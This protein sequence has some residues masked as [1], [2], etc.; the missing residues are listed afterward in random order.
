M[1]SYNAGL[2]IK[3]T[4]KPGRFMKF[5]SDESTLSNTLV[6]GEGHGIKVSID[7]V[8]GVINAI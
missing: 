6:A 5:E 7:E 2:Q 3:T 1:V 4:L 8:N